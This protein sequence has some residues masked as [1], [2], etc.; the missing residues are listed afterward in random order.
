M[1]L[2]IQV[3]FSCLYLS[4][5]TMRDGKCQSAMHNLRK[6]PFS[7]DLYHFF[8]LR[9]KSQFMDESTDF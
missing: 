8:S 5:L 6:R 7:T 2:V 3:D 1:P 9:T 4:N